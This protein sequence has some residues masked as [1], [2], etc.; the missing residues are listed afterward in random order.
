MLYFFDLFS[1]NFWNKGTKVCFFTASLNVAT[2]TTQRTELKNQFFLSRSRTSHTLP[3]LLLYFFD[4][5]SKNFWNKGTKV[6]FFTASSNVTTLT[7]QG[8]ELKNEF[9]YLSRS[10]TSHTHSLPCCYISLT[11]SRGTLGIKEP[12]FVSSL[13]VQTLQ[14]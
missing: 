14:H 6:C 8:T 13:Q 10:R 7:T 2:L 3:P 4:L 12:T 11:Y 1:K 9:F 5:F